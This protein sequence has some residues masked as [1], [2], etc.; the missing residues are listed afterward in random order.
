M[1]RWRTPGRWLEAA[2]QGL[3]VATAI[4]AF[5]FL[6]SRLLGVAR[7]AAIADAFGASPELDAYWVA[8]RV[9][10][11]IFQL[12]A[13]ATLGS[14]FIPVFARIRRRDGPDAAWALASNALTIVMA[15]TAALCLVA[16]ALAPLLVPLFAPGLGE[17]IGRG[18][19]LTAEAVRLTRIMLLSPLLLAISGM[20]TGILNAR[21][22]FLLPA[23]APMLYNLGII[24][25]ALAL[26]GRWGVD[27]G[28]EGLAAGV[29]AGSAAHLLVQLP[30]LAR[31]GMR[32]RWRFDFGDGPTR[33]VARLMG[34][35]VIG[36][37]AAQVNFAVTTTFFA[38]RVGASAISNLT[39]AWLIANLP[40]A[41][42]GMALA[43]AAF[44][45][46]AEQAAGSDGRALVD[47]V[48]RVLRTT[49]F[50][51]V[52]AALGLALLRE[53]ATTVLL[54]RGAF[55][56]G[57]SA[58][59]AAA[60]GFFCLGIVPQAAVE[61]H[62]RGF[63]AL[64]DT[65]TP[66]ILTVGAVVVNIIL[67][68]LLWERFGVEGLAASLAISSWLE[69]IFLYWLYALRTGSTGAAL[70]D[71]HAIARIALAGA[72]MALFLGVVLPAIDER[73]VAASWVTTLAGAIAGG[74]VYLAV[75]LLLRVREVEDARDR[76]RALLL[77]R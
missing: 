54:E 60:L 30:G 12:L 55:G 35:R 4:V 44:P 16:L 40:V 66:V 15:A 22:Q 76:L 37:A 77:R 19:E 59:T 24:A 61:I 70:R 7:T 32:Y 43:T 27:W 14:A 73:G 20:I 31:E 53:P 65:R 57:D 23:L 13:G 64:G 39:F 10:D 5:G 1:A 2:P 50:L 38:S 41:L 36:L 72:A 11:L 47:T 3:A 68:A 33:E 69:W 67:S 71:L 9:P 52:P 58:V 34:P 6:G 8:F 62:S 75:S 17:D 45:R 26:T 48:S 74:A 29:V 28:V 63:Y 18:D 42:F 46:L 21:Q 49:L 51:S 25:G 56:A